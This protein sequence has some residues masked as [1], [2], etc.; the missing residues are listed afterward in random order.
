VLPAPPLAAPIT[1]LKPGAKGPAVT[2]LQQRLL[3]LGF[4]IDEADGQ[5]GSVTRQAVMAFQK[6]NGM[7]ASGAVDAA[8]ADALTGATTR[9]AGQATSANGD[10]VEVDKG[11]QVLYLL[12]GGTTVWAFNIST[13]S[14]K[15]YTE[16]NQKTGQPISGD[17]HTP[18]GVFKV[19]REYSD[20]WENGELGELY[21]PKY[22]KGGVAIHG[23]TNV[24]NVPA[25]HGC[26]R[27]SV[28]AM[29][30]MW[31]N[32][33]LPKGTIVWVHD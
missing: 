24:P 16:T 15:P 19:Y 30:W 14:D 32:D 23:H 17:A 31:A 11:R 2:A 26:V 9:V 4:W 5:Y 20:G 22:F 28:E 1:P 7:P 21:R 29:D 3:D 12:R 6:H 18:T 10:L 27:V 25:S 8:T 13:G 33:V